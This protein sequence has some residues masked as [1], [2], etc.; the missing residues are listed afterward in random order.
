MMENDRTSLR[1]DLEECVEFFESHWH[2]AID[3]REFLPPT[4]ASNFSEIVCEL[5]RI[6][7]E[8]RWKGGERPLVES[9]LC[10]LA[11]K[12]SIRQI[13]EL[14]FEEYRLRH[15]FDAP[16]APEQFANRLGVSTSDWPKW[17]NCRSGDDFEH[18]ELP[19]QFPQ[20][21]QSING[22]ELVGLLGQGAFGCVFLAR[23]VDLANRFVA[24]KVTEVSR[25]EPDTLA[26]LQHT[27]IV[28]IYSLQ[29]DAGL[30]TICMPFLGV[31]TLRDVFG[32]TKDDANFA[33]SGQ[34]LISTIAERKANTV[35][36]TTSPVT[37]ASEVESVLS[38]TERERR[39]SINGLS[40]HETLLWMT[41]RIADGLEFAHG[42]GIV[43]GDLKPEN[44][45]IG[46]D[47]QPIIL[48]FHLARDANREAPRELVG[49]T[50][51][52]M[53][54]DQLL[55]LIATGQLA[56]KCDLFALG[57]ILFEGLSGQQPYP[58]RGFD[59][60]SIQQMIADRR[61]PPPRLRLINSGVSVDVESIVTKCLEP[62]LDRRYQTAEQIRIDIDRHLA[63]QPLR[64]APNRSLRERIGKWLHR[65]PR[66][67]SVTVMTFVGLVLAIITASLV[68]AKLSRAARFEAIQNSERFVTNL[69][70]A[71]SP[72]T[73]MQLNGAKADQQ[74]TNILQLL[75][76]KT[77]PILANG[78]IGARNQIELRLP[79]EVRSSEKEAISY[80]KYWLARSMCTS[81]LN[82]TAP[83]QRDDLL[84]QAIDVLD[85]AT[86]IEGN[87][88]RA[89]SQMQAY[90]WQ[91]LG[92]SERGIRLLTARGQDSNDDSIG[93]TDQLLKAAELRR[94][95]NEKGALE[96]LNQL[97]TSHTNDFQVWLLKGH[98]HLRLG[99]KEKAESSY[100]ICIGLDEES[101]W[102][103]FY[104]GY[105]RLEQN[106]FTQA[107]VDFSRCL[108]ID[109]DDSDA[110]L[111][112]AL[113]HRGLQE[114]SA[115]I[116]DLSCA[117]ERGCTQTRAYY[118]RSQM[119][120]A[121][122][123]PAAA[124]RDLAQ[125]LL[126][127]PRDEKSC[128]ARGMAHISVNNPSAALADFQ[129]ALKFNPCSVDAWQNIATVQAEYLNNQVA[130]IAALTHIVDEH[131]DDQ[132]ARV[133]RGVLYAR[134]GNRTAALVDAR[135]ALQSRPDADIQYRA[136]GIFALLDNRDEDDR[137]KALELLY[138]AAFIDPRIVLSR[139]SND[140]DLRNLK[141]D[142][143]Y[144]NLLKS[145]ASLAS[146]E[147]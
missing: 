4:T 34:E 111:N 41:A 57:V 35:M 44:V 71:I 104:R 87:K 135:A 138:R 23:Q 53:S 95:G 64:F 76:E 84:R 85:S 131:S 86:D 137:G 72:L 38:A 47:G 80:A 68:S 139:A 83:D 121:L 114:F 13:G 93:I 141:D 94:D 117:I 55:T 36:A 17:S 19:I 122:K 136:A 113:A 30:Q 12:L 78:K 70:R 123:N 32:R 105:C 2:S 20:V 110:Y 42:K 33:K 21:G 15:Q 77:E 109:D 65:H 112:R 99:E 31:I 129:S 61:A 81:A 125:F 147:N 97:L 79:K 88:S 106:E 126:L 56:K 143:A 26:R 10:G 6:D 142:L 108:K 145:L 107:I 116:A 91:L 49:G 45:L 5:I 59:D 63:Y 54:A 134:V 1:D 69:Y 82:L 58:H 39:L 52:Y 120:L 46:D 18:T 133:T 100:S 3:L 11:V 96:V 115:A 128:L 50:I 140:T 7:L 124:Q 25:H 8:Y 90:L 62:A 48:D 102:G 27:N 66:L 67:P 28:P 146:R 43:H 98:T 144:K 130:G 101:P 24:V 118:L 75:D 92:D 51:P 40:L 103:Y 127:E 119:N 29:R 132:V 89:G 9:Y 37:K 74:R 22:Y 73:G 14:A 16:I 60:E